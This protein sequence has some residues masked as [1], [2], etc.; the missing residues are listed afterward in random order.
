MAGVLLLGTMLVGCGK[1]GADKSAGQD[2]WPLTASKQ[3]VTLHVEGM[4]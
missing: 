4:T 3:T 2:A 1:E